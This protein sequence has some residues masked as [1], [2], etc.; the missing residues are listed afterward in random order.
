M[1]GETRQAVLAR[2]FERYVLAG[3][4]GLQ[5][6]GYN[7]TL[8]LQ[9]VR[10]HG[11]VEATKRL[12]SSAAGTSTG[13]ATLWELGR[14]DASV[15]YAVCLPW[16]RELFSDEESERAERRLDLHEFPLQR[17]REAEQPEWYLDL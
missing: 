1:S 15:E 14:L 5:R 4:P 2:E 12:L 8:F 9:M 6:K 7:P 10:R 13:F 17:I 3:I 16:F 11:A